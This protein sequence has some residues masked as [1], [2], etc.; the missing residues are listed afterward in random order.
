[1]IRIARREYTNFLRRVFLF[2]EKNKPE[3]NKSPEYQSIINSWLK[4]VLEEDI[5]IEKIFIREGGDRPSSEVWERALVA[6]SGLESYRKHCNFIQPEIFKNFHL[7]VATAYGVTPIYSLGKKVF[8]AVTYPINHKLSS[9]VFNYLQDIAKRI[10]GK[11]P[12][13]KL[14]V[15]RGE[16]L[17]K[18]IEKYSAP[19]GFCRDCS[20]LDLVLSTKPGLPRFSVCTDS[21]SSLEMLAADLDASIIERE[22]ALPGEG[23]YETDNRAVIFFDSLITWAQKKD[24]SDFHVKPEY[25]FVSNDFVGRVLFQIPGGI[26]PDATMSRK[27]L[28]QVVARLKVMGNMDVANHLDPQDGRVCFTTSEGRYVI[29]LSTSPVEGGEWACGR[30]FPLQVKTI[31]NLGLDSEQQ[32]LLKHRLSMSQGM[33]L[34]SG[35]TG[36]G[37]STSLAASMTYIR[38]SR[39][40][41]SLMVTIEDPIEQLLPGANIVQREFRE[42]RDKSMANIIKEMMRKNP[43]VIMVGEIRDSDT[44]STAFR[45]VLTGHLL[46]STVHAN[47]S[48][49]AF[50]RLIDLGVERFKVAYT[51]LSVHQRLVPKA[52][53][54]C[55]EIVLSGT[56]EFEAQR[57]SIIEFGRSFGCSP[58]VEISKLVQIRGC[59]HCQKSGYKGYVPLFE[60]LPVTTGIKN[61][62]LQGANSSEI[63]SFA[64]KESGTKTIPEQAI[65]LIVNGI[66]TPQAV[67]HACALA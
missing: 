56:P 64:Q 40:I 45:A 48:A 4:Q 43:G 52:C 50:T 20:D 27:S 31:E 16:D 3:E 37:K 59:N 46:L 12:E 58:A 54:K 17:R 51:I 23:L 47:G 57:K 18:L 24:A 29:R 66:T 67:Y 65:D 41:K 61:L 39:A 49:A 22:E 25:D 55:R 10:I 19:E 21:Y 34:F 14:L 35:P 53:D 30:L 7:I 6:V 60:F 1:M 44:A 38:D 15:S 9:E 8:F 11:D 32:I 62:I 33:I 28:K 2:L 5:P 36:S 26:I 42:K 63:L 13:I